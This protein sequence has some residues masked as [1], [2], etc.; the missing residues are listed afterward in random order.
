MA[1]DPLKWGDIG[2]KF[3]GA[4]FI[5]PFENFNGLAFV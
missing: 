3:H 2:G 4:D 1:K 5:G